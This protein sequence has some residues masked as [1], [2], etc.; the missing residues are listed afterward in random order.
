MLNVR[1]FKLKKKTIVFHFQNKKGS[2]HSVSLYIHQNL[3]LNNK[4]VKTCVKGK[5]L[6][7]SVEINEN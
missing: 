5:G 2:L 3:E 6:I 4:N 1:A 7:L